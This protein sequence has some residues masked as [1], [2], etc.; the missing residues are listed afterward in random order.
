LRWR[1]EQPCHVYLR[2]AQAVNPPGT[3]TRSA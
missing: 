1:Y 3:N 2:F